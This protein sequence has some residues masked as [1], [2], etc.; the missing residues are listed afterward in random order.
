MAHD[1]GKESVVA[2]DDVLRAMARI[3]EV[4]AGVDARRYRQSHYRLAPHPCD[5]HGQA[6]VG[7]IPRHVGLTCPE[8]FR[9]AG[10]VCDIATLR[11]EDG[12]WKPEQIMWEHSGGWGIDWA[13]K[14]PE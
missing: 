14:I 10:A 6:M 8:C 1:P 4:K 7:T 13:W 9:T 11:L 2:P 12:C 5:I 3:R